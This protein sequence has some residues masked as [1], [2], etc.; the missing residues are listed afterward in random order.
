MKRAVLVL[1]IFMLTVLNACNDNKTSKNSIP[2]ENQPTANGEMV[3]IIAENWTFDKD[4]YVV[5][6]GEITVN[7]KN[8]EGFHGIQIDG[9]D[10]SIEGD[11]SFTTTL[12]PGEY[13][14]FC[15]IICGTGHSNMVATLVVEE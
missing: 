8:I 6:A 5:P 7:L 12:E 11:G 13:T 15:S 4:S 10:V 2:I 9:T 3:D 14:I 1:S